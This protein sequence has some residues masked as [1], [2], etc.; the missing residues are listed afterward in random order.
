MHQRWS[1]TPRLR[2]RRLTSRGCQRSVEQQQLADYPGTF[3]ILIFPDAM[4][5]RGLML[6]VRAR[7]WTLGVSHNHFVSEEGRPLVDRQY[8]GIDLHRRRSL[9]V[10]TDAAG[11]VLEEV[12]IDNDPLRLPAEIAKAGPQPEVA[13]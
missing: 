6:P 9:N 5:E 12:R 3:E 8:V 4:K 13:L 10:R 2:R 11:E 1:T 7:C